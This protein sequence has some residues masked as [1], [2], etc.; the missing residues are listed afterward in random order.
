[1]AG[2]GFDP[3][4]AAPG[5][6]A[7]LYRAHAVQVVPA[8]AYSEVKPGA[9]WKRP[10]MRSWTEYQEALV[11]QEQFDQWYGTSG[12]YVGRPNMGA[13]CGRASGGMFVIDLDT[14]KHPSAAAW[15]Q[16]LL[17]VHNN[18]MELETPEQR[19]GGGGYQKLFRAP[20]AWVPP[21]C[22]TSIGVDIRGQG[23]F[24][25]FAPSVH[26][27]GRSY[28]WLDG[29]SPDDVDIMIA[30]DWLVSAVNELVVEH[31]G[32]SATNGTAHSDAYAK[33]TNVRPDAGAYDGFGHQTDGREEKMRD[34]IWAAIVDWY[35]ECPIKPAEAESHAR[36]VDKYAVYEDLVSPQTFDPALTKTA[37]LDREGRGPTAFHVKWRA[38]MRHWDDKVAE[39]AKQPGKSNGYRDYTDEFAKAK[40]DPTTGQPLPLILTA[41]EFVAGFTPP[42]YLVD[43]V[44]Q[45]GYLYSLTARTGH[46]K[47]AVALYI[48]QCIAR[49]HDMHGCPVKGGTV[50]FCAG[51]NPDDIRARF[52]V[53]AKFYGFDP[54][55]IKIRFISGVIS[56]TERLAQI[57]A[58]AAL[59]DDLVLVI[60]DTA[61]AYFQGDET[62][63]NSQQG[64]YA[65]VLRELTFLLPSKPAAIV[66]CH[67]VKNASRD[68]LIPMG[69]SAFL[70]EVDGNLTLW[71]NSEKQTSLHWLGKFRGPEFDPM[72][73]EVKTALSDRV[74]DAEGRLMPSV[75]ARPMS[76]EEMEASGIDA[77]KDEDRLMRVLH[78]NPKM[79]F[80]K[81]AVKTG[82]K[83]RKVQMVM[84]RLHD[85]KFVTQQRNGKYVLS[86]KG[87]DEIGVV[88]KGGKDD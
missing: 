13:I 65:R 9:S 59:I 79:S 83:K 70:N 11:P 51:E 88:S 16:G 75:I 82:W 71:A 62:N 26:E 76:E 4:F 24:A 35:R 8:C 60:V 66:C 80:S 44:L 84:Q 31:G 56:F 48:A 54:E 45:R 85:D 34:L 37:M 33:R 38:A 32:G 53:L 40:V 15:W 7:R 21:T 87:R 5:E 23:G 64:A 61:A 28:E 81:L 19:T 52:L 2:I 43:G 74:K 46:G 41:K 86:D 18:R 55:L 42:A 68:N 72:G 36:M 29:L 39:E 20:P 57:R 17:S 3:E 12:Q 30:P 27:S 25:M 22:K 10:L 14:Y 67:P 73:F 50:L 1:M 6:W 58:E 69:G 49:G 78:E 77:E 63:S 47:T